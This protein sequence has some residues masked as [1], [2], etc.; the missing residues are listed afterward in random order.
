MIVWVRAGDTR[1]EAA[2]ARRVLGEVSGCSGKKMLL[3][4]LVV[5]GWYIPSIVMNLADVPVPE[6]RNRESQMGNF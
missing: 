4:S 5:S 2:A 6:E 1:A 3:V